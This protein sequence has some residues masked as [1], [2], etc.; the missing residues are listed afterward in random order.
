MNTLHEEFG[1]TLMVN[2]ACNLRCTY[3]YTGAKFSSPM[4]RETGEAAIGRALCS[5]APGG[6]LGLGFFGGEPLLEA[7]HILEWMVHA[8]AAAAEAGKQV[9]FHMTTNGTITHAEAWQVMLAGDLTLAVSCDGSPRLHDRHRRDTQGRGS[10]AQVEATLRRLVETGKFFTVV[11]VVRPDNLDDVPEGLEYL[12][13]LGVR[14]V[15]LSLDLWTTWSSDDGRRLQQLIQLAA[16]L[17]RSWLPDFG[18]SWFDS[19]AGALAGAPAEEI[20][21]RCG[22]GGGEI[23]VAPSGNLY[24]CERLIGEDAPIQPM[25]LPGHALEGRDFLTL[26]PAAFARHEACTRCALLTACDTTCRC[27]NFIRTGDQNRPDGLLC[28]L[29]KATA[30]ASAKVLAIAAIV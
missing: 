25:R 1:L 10:A 7:G 24:P 5:L 19:K 22:F 4:A 6:R 23:A 2:H 20:S 27:S 8:R 9:R 3:C 13:A 30:S 14:Q 11:F 16:G 18:L 28:L 17:W 12:H 21:T 29:N 15:D 26:A